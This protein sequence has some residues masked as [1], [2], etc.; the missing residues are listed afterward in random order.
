[1]SDNPSVVYQGEFIE[2]WIKFDGVVY[3][4]WKIDKNAKVHIEETPYKEIP[5][6]MF[7]GKLEVRVL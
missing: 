4:I 6:T 2:T 1:M 3:R 5:F 7:D